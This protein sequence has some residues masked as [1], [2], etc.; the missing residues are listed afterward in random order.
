MSTVSST[1]SRSAQRGVA[2]PAARTGERQPVKR[3]SARGL[4]ALLL[5]A[6]VASLV[7]IADQLIDTWAD[8]HLLL[9]WITLWA[10][11]FVGLALFADAARQAAA[12]LLARLDAWAR[13]AAEG[14]AEARL[15][16]MAQQDPRLMKELMAARQRDAGEDFEQALAPLDL[17]PAPT[18]AAR[19]PSGDRPSPQAI[20]RMAR[21]EIGRVMY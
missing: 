19:H 7:V 15:W 9:A 16:A 1:L 18:P 10:V 4:T 8:G 17:M 3:G 21:R 11:V 2:S 6:V 13:T 20:E 12:S 14:R 5:A